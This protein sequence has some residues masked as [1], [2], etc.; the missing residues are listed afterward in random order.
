MIEHFSHA[1]I[2]SFTVKLYA[3]ES[4]VLGFGFG[5]TPTGKILYKQIPVSPI[6]SL[7]TESGFNGG[8]SIVGN[9]FWEWS[10]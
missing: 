4:V 8:V 10:G 2:V 6:N 5:C 3:E 9:I 7:S 1:N